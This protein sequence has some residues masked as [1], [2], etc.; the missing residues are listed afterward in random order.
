ML[1]MKILTVSTLLL[2]GVV[3]AVWI[4]TPSYVGESSPKLKSS[5]MIIYGE[6]GVLSV[7]NVF[8]LGVQP[9]SMRSDPTQSDSLQGD[10]TDAYIMG[11]AALVFDKL[12]LL[13]RLEPTGL[14]FDP[15]A[16]LRIDTDWLNEAEW[17]K[18]KLYYLPG[19]IRGEWIQVPDASSQ[20]ALHSPNA[21]SFEISHFTLY[22][23]SKD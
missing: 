23:L 16:R 18:L 10:G 9:N 3:L 15:P 11:E 4:L 5:K 8:E 22:A 20:V 19:G 13:L 14:Q 17:Y 21:I 12:P 2:L 6:G 1:G 7:K